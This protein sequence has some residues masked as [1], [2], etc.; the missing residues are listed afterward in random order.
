MK[1]LPLMTGN[2]LPIFAQ[3]RALG[4]MKRLAQKCCHSEAKRRNL[5]FAVAVKPFRDR[6]AADSSLLSAVA[7]RRAGAALG[8]TPPC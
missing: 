2:I 7:L 8:M 5:L 3:S 6:I 4:V 1:A